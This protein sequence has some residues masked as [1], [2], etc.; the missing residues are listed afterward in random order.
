VLA[1]AAADRVTNTGKIIGLD[2][3][4]GMLAVARRTR[5][6]IEWHEGDIKELP[7]DDAVFN[8]VVSQFAL[9]YFNDRVAA[10]SEMMRVLK[11]GGRLAVAVWGPFEHAISYVILTDIARRRCDD[12]AADVLTSPF[13]LGN[14]DDLLDLFRSAGIDDAMVELHPGLMSFPSIATFVEAEI[15]GS[16]LAELLDDSDYMALLT[17][18]EE[19]L[20]QFQT[21]HGDVVMPL[22]AYIAT[23]QKA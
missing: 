7:F 9:M 20:Q 4:P 22:N 1:R 15:K 10:L 11:P 8:V 23:A 14:K 16:P 3:N 5:P 6:E 18:A 13:V 12:A 2:R 17:E 21:V 19:R